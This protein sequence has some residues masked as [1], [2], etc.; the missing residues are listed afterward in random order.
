MN[1]KPRPPLCIAGMHRS[2]TSFLTRMLHFCGLDLGDPRDL[3]PPQKDNPEGFWE[4]LQFVRLN[5]EILQKLGGG[6]DFPPELAPGWEHD[7]ILEPLVVPAAEVVLGFP[8]D[9]PWGWKDPRNSLT[10][11][12]WKRLLRGCQVIV[13]VRNPLD[14]AAS[15]RKR[16]TSSEAFSLHLW[17]TYHESL[18]RAGPDACI[19]THFDAL[20]AEP[21]RELERILRRLDWSVEPDRLREAAA[22]VKQGR[23]ASRSTE[24]DLKARGE[25][26]LLDLY[27][28]FAD[29]AGDTFQAIRARDRQY[30]FGEG[31][32]PENGDW[33]WMEGSGTVYLDLAEDREVELKIWC[34]PSG[35]YDRFPFSLG[36]S[37]DGMEPC[38]IQVSRP[39]KVQAVRV[40]VHREQPF[41]AVRLSSQ[42]TFV[43]ARLGVNQDTRRL[44]L[45]VGEI[46][47]C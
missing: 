5:D 42:E 41:P 30:S 29:R 37:Q 32:Y 16:A 12:F 47:V 27:R 19:V 38:R 33:R 21:E 44:S 31:F 2:G 3:M 17:K 24:F 7:P 26:A 46:G 40:R 43:P 15:L 23:S 1:E 45:R 4:N 11:P 20:L 34:A 10:L 36:I 18:L 22:L 28:A 14:V 35:H 9:R 25:T 6:W 13:C 8:A 39:A